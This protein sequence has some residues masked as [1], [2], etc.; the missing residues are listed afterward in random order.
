MN[1][2]ESQLAA[3]LE[4]AHAALLHDLL[5]LERA[6]RTPEQASLPKLRA[7]L[8]ATQAH[9]AKHFRFEEQDGY[10]DAIRKREP[11][12]QRV[13]DD[14]AAQHGQLSQ[15]LAVLRADADKANELDVSLV[16]RIRAWLA[17]VR[18]HEDRENQLVQDAFNLDL[19]A[20]D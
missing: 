8:E 19:G 1:K 12:L 5:E 6:L 18:Q 9:I 7:R 17:A 13:V 3:A 14:L 11:R 15:L 10:M 4:R 2:V 16:E 20:E